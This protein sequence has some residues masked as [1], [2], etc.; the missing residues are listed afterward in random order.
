MKSYN[1]ILKSSN[2]KRKILH[3][4][5]LGKSLLCL[6]F[7]CILGGILYIKFESSYGTWNIY[8]VILVLS[9]IGNIV[10]VYLDNIFINKINRYRKLITSLGYT[11][12]II[13]VIVMFNLLIGNYTISNSY[14]SSVMY[15]INL[16]KLIYLS[17]F[18]IFILGAFICF[19]NSLDLDFRKGY[20]TKNNKAGNIKKIIKTVSKILCYL[21]LF[22]G[23][24]AAYVI[25]SKGYTRNLEM[26]IS[27]FSMFY[28]I[29]FLSIT[30][31]LLNL[32]RNKI[33]FSY[34]IVLTAGIFIFTVC[35]GSIV[36]TPYT[37]AKAE[38]SFTQVYEAQW[39]D[40]IY[41]ES[42]KYFLKTQFCIPAYFLGI[43]SKNYT[44]KK[45]I[46]F[47]EEKDSDG[48][49]VS[50]YFDVYSPSND[51][52][53]LPGIGYTIIRIHGGAWVAGDKG[54]LNILQMNK[55]LAQQGYTVFDI[56][57]GLTN[58]SSFT[59]ELGEPEHVKGS[60][61]VDDMVKHIGIFT[62]Y[63]D[64]H[65]KEYGVNLE[66]IFFSGGS[67]GGH[68]AATSG[69]AIES[70]KYKG[71]FSPKIKVKGLILFYPANGLPKIGDIDGEGN[72]INP[73]ELVDRNSPPCLI[74]QG[75]RDGLV[76]RKIS[77]EF[78]KKY[79]EKKN[80]NCIILW[81]FLGNHGSDY[82]F[83]GNYNQVFLY[84]ME[85]FM[86]ISR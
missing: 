10:L 82:Y 31:M 45:D 16:Y 6:N 76:P 72:F 5:V 34:Y 28:G 66:N 17:Y 55:Y 19:L 13:S 30:V 70:E 75:T 11:Y 71:V 61:K 58:K 42:Q 9:L 85:R 23:V 37:I 50:L 24:V 78:Q 77:T 12:L 47:Y 73:Q 59:T 38:K 46:L 29:I 54:E 84:Y 8:G 49:Q 35:M 27:Q 7:I 81:M 51:L 62:K 1:F 43:K 65:S 69:L 44:V 21:S 33:G 67:A 57:Y 20:S 15:N 68:L 41:K 36:L 48:K 4:N 64:N 40:K 74:F 52:K 53:D 18:T 39:R 56:Q 80:K 22:V 86:L 25:L 60:F 32:K 26:F 79:M 83:P 14:D 63:I 3:L 2:N